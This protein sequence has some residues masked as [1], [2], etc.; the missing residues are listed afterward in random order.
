MS[1]AGRS[2]PRLVPQLAVLGCWYRVLCWFAGHRRLSDPGFGFQGSCFVGWSL[3]SLGQ[4][5]EGVF[6]AA[7]AVVAGSRDAYSGADQS[8]CASKEYDE[9]NSPRLSL[10]GRGSRVVRGGRCV[11]LVRGG[12]R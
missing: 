12:G 9:G 4:V 6:G 3:G 11:A 1:W 2:V 7:V 5:E 8:G 10:C